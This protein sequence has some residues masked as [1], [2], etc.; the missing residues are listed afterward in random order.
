MYV[1]C[2]L[3]VCVCVCVVSIDLTP[4]APLDRPS[5]GLSDPWE[6]DLGEA[7]M[8][9]RENTVYPSEIWRGGFL[10]WAGITIQ[11]A[12][13]LNI[14]QFGQI[15]MSCGC[16]HSLAVA[17]L[18]PERLIPDLP[19]Q[20]LATWIPPSLP[21]CNS[22]M[23]KATAYIPTSICAN[24]LA[25]FDWMAMDPNNQRFYGRVW[26]ALDWLAQMTY[27]SSSS[28]FTIEKP[29]TTNSTTDKN[30]SVKE[31]EAE[32]GTTSSMQANNEDRDSTE[33]NSNSEPKP[34][35]RIANYDYVMKLDAIA[36]TMVKH[37]NMTAEEAERETMKVIGALAPP[38]SPPPPAS[39]ASTSIAAPSASNNH[40]DS[41]SSSTTTTT[42]I[43][44]VET[45]DSSITPNSNSDKTS[46]VLQLIDSD[47]LPKWVY[48][49]VT[50]E[51]PHLPR[52]P[53][54]SGGAINDFLHSI[55]H[56]G[57]IGF[58]PADI[59]CPPVVASHGTLDGVANYKSLE[60][61]GKRC[62]WEVKGYDGVGHNFNMPEMW[63]VV[64]ASFTQ[65]QDIDMKEFLKG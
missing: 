39:S 58:D 14:K 19:M 18:F 44:T 42:T 49:D 63:E 8:I 11:I 38:A 60:A 29:T 4:D 22:T 20:L 53:Y 55:E 25:T 50:P 31:K 30:A 28:I 51:V 16:M 45:N 54:L 46:S 3:C 62:G 34:S 15:G 36:Y 56:T 33:S 1:V 13:H 41:S 52:R 27:L 17:H 64:F 47:D 7:L 2:V 61:L 23:I 35:R 40:P 24:T 12:D 10:D 32:G 65:S 48:A 6:R 5:T 21:E 59:K 9:E 57:T 43:T 37:P 26:G